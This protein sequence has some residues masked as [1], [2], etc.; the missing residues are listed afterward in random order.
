MSRLSSEDRFDWV[1]DA[2]MHA[3]IKIPMY[4]AWFLLYF[5][6]AAPVVLIRLSVWATAGL[7][8]SK[9]LPFWHVVLSCYPYG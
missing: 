5:S 1:S 6:L 3:M 8:W 2:H 7:V 4:S 9:S